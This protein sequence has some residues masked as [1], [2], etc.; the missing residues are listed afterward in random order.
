MSPKAAT[1]QRIG[2]ALLLFAIFLRSGSAD[3]SFT[4]WAVAVVGLTIV[5]LAWFASRAARVQERRRSNLESE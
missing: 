3:G 1:I 5:V 4:A 2:L